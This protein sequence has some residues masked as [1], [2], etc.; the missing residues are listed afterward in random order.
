VAKEERE[1]QQTPKQN[2][3]ASDR[4]GDEET[5]REFHQPPAMRSE[6]RRAS[7]INANNRRFNKACEGRK[8]KDTTNY[9]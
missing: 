6:P 1:E 5:E 8:F 2:S 3:A 7:R 4:R 9:R